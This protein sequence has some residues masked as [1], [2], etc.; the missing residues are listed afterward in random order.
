MS[1]IPLYIPFH[2]GMSWVIFPFA[3]WIK[4]SSVKFHWIPLDQIAWETMGTN[5]RGFDEDIMEADSKNRS[6]EKQNMP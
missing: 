6:G 5:H 4:S 3:T 2:K 1:L